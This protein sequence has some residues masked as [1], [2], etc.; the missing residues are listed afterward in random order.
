MNFYLALKHLHPDL[1]VDRD[2]T[3]RDDGEGV[4]IHSWNAERPKPTAQEV[5]DAWEVIKNIPSEPNETEQ[6]KRRLEE[7]E[8]AILMLM[9]MQI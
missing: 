8:N 1:E 9:D 6:I 2:Y 3:L 4:Y 7:T 5:V